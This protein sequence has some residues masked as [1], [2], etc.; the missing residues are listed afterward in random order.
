MNVDH[1]GLTTHTSVPEHLRVSSVSLSWPERYW[2]A[3]RSDMPWLTCPEVDPCDPH[4]STADVVRWKELGIILTDVSAAITSGRYI[5]SSGETNNVSIATTVAPAGGLTA[6]EFEILDTWWDAPGPC[7]D[8]WSRTT[9]DHQNR[10]W[11]VWN[12]YPNAVLPVRSRLLGAAPI[13]HEILSA[14][15]VRRI[16]SN[17]LMHLTEAVVDRS[18]LY[19]AQLARATTSTT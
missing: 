10:L 6:Q 11:N 5:P 8:P 15:A 7:A 13:A 4:S 14:A 2:M 9:A 19:V 18:P 1:G 17:G 16:A 3:S 12:H